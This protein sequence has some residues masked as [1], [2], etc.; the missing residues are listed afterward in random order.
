MPRTHRSTLHKLAKAYVLVGKHSKKRLTCWVHRLNQGLNLPDPGM[1]GDENLMYSYTQHVAAMFQLAGS[2]SSSAQSD[3][4]AAVALESSLAAITAPSDQLL[5]P[6]LT[7]NKLNVS[8]L[9]TIAPQLPWSMFL[10]GLGYP[11][12]QQL[13]VEWPPYFGNMSALVAAKSPSEWIPYL[14]YAI[15]NS[16]STTLPRYLHDRRTIT[17]CRYCR[18]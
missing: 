18:R 14:R 5:D 3:A 16:F 12:V 13:N 7:Y 2:S 15:L 6:F 17:E 4:Q 10:Q 9:Q 1:Y 11:D 8:G